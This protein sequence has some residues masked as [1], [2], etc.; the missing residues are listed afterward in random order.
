MVDPNNPTNNIPIPLNGAGCVSGQDLQ[1]G[2][3]SIYTTDSNDCESDTIQFEISKV[4]I[5]IVY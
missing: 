3:Y 2:S 5:L 4:T 1:P